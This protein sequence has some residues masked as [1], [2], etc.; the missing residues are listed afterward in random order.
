MS[1]LRS[2]WRSWA[3][4]HQLLWNLVSSMERRECLLESTSST[5]LDFPCLCLIT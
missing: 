2:L 5:M 4:F 3:W 1:I